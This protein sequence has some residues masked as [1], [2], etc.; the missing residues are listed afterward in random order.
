MISAIL[1]SVDD[2]SDQNDDCNRQASKKGQNM[3]ESTIA[4]GFVK[5]FIEFSVEKGANRTQLLNSAGI[6]DEA[7]QNVENRIPLSNYLSLVE[8]AKVHCRE[9]ALALQFGETP[10]AAE[11]SI[12]YLICRS[13]RTVQ[14]ALE[15]INR[16]SQLA[17]DADGLDESQGY[18]IKHD[19]GGAWIELTQSVYKKYPQLVE[20]ALARIVSGASEY[21][22]GKPFALEVHLTHPP[23]DYISEYQR[24]FKVPVM[25]NSQR[26]AVLVEPAFLS[27]EISPHSDYVF[28]ILSKHAEAM[29]TQLKKNKSMR[30]R[31][32]SILIPILHKGS[33]EMSNVA[34]E[35]NLTTQTLYRR[36]K[37]EGVNF[38]QLVDQLKHKM[39]LH[40]LGERQVSI[41]EATYLLGFSEPSAFSRAFKRWTG[42]S[43]KQKQEGLI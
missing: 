35:L 22:R 34:D 40:Y 5:A 3:L 26:N 1:G 15:Q 8:E 36:L 11:M 39:A 31:V 30:G 16:Y 2:G 20:S 43:P 17:F 37:D 24:I 14:E 19:N 18:V 42:V 7:L 23:C 38:E 9:P 21:F 10:L 12:V 4:A 27:Y 29:L 41:K 32:E 6:S 28:G 13:V 25:F 33:I